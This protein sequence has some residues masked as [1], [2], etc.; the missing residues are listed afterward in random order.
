MNILNWR[1]WKTV[2]EETKSQIAEGKE[3]SATGAER[4][5]QVRKLAN[6]SAEVRREDQGMRERNRFAQTFWKA[7]EEGMR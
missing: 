5:E 1:W 6:K 4:L 2:E 7:F 3:A